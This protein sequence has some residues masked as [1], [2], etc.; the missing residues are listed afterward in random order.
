[1]GPE[2]E[3]VQNWPHRSNLCYY[4][5][6]KSNG[7]KHNEFFLVTCWWHD[8]FILSPNFLK[9]VISFKATWLFM[10]KKITE[11]LLTAGVISFKTTWLFMGR[12]FTRRLLTTGVISFKSNVLFVGRFFTGHLLTTGV[13]MKFV[14]VIKICRVWREYVESLFGSL[15]MF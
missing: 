8:T 14:V 15:F 1:M 7:K 13:M 6:E 11:R 12:F 9:L 3:L 4:I 10:G 5:L 2:V